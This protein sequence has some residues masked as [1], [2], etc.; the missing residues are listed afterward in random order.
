MTR[1][2]NTY[3]IRKHCY[4]PLGVHFLTRACMGAHDAHV[5]VPMFMGSTDGWMD[6]FCNGSYACHDVG[7]V[8]GTL[9]PYF[10]VALPGC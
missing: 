9:A 4:S 10:H 2:V 6:G 8:F 1:I 3:D 5:W 7:E